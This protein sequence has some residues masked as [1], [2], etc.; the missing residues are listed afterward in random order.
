MLCSDKETEM[1]KLSWAA[2]RK[3]GCAS[4]EREGMR[5]SRIPARGGK[6]CF[7]KGFIGGVL[8]PRVVGVLAPKAFRPSKETGAGSHHLPTSVSLGSR[9]HH[10]P[11]AIHSCLWEAMEAASS[12]SEA[13]GVSLEKHCSEGFHLVPSCFPQIPAGGLRSWH[14]KAWLDSQ[15]CMPLNLL[16]WT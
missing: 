13:K 8:S 16:H 12:V 6:C 5:M 7:F 10:H 1:E 14:L 2:S 11:P 15:P 4:A 3:V 9:H